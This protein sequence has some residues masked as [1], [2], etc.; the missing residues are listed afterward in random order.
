MVDDHQKTRQEVQQWRL[1]AS[2]GG[3][4][5]ESQPNQ[6]HTQTKAQLAKLSGKAFDHA[7]LTAMLREHAKE[8]KDLTQHSLVETKEEVRSGRRG[9]VPVVKEDLTQA[10]TI[11]SSLGISTAAFNE[12]LQTQNILVR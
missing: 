11:A 3:V 7:Y 5:L 2:D 8:L 4:R 1:M 6:S 10:T 9:A 12:G